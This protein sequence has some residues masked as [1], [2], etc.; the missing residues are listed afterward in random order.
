MKKQLASMKFKGWVVVIAVFG[1]L[2]IFLEGKEFS[3]GGATGIR[4]KTDVCIFQII[5]KF[6]DKQWNKKP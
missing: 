6:L 4:T 2:I 3:I 5:D 1:L